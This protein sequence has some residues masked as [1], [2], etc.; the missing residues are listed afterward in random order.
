M[1]E[2][3][4]SRDKLTSSMYMIEVC[5]SYKTHSS[6][7]VGGRGG[8]TSERLKFDPDITQM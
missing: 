7:V 4:K 1:R 5:Y 3:K 8:I 2:K 6:E